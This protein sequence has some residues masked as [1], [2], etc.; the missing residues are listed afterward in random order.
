M[1]QKEKLHEL[2][3]TLS[4]FGHLAKDSERAALS[5]VVIN[6]DIGDRPYVDICIPGGLEPSAEV[7]ALLSNGSQPFR[8]ALAAR[9]LSENKALIYANSCPRCGKLPKTPRA[10][11]CPWCLHSWRE[12]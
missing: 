9:L 4:N 5:A 11:Q 1:D 10:K 3:Y 2:N 12:S 7:R 6:V 8:E